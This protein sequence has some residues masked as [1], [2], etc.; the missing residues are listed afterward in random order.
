MLCFVGSA[1]A[2]CEARSCDPDAET[3]TTC[4]LDP[5]TQCSVDGISL[6]RANGCI[7]IG[8]KRGNAESMLGLDDDEFEQLILEAFD[9]WTSVDCGNGKHP[10]IEVQSIGAVDTK[11]RFTCKPMPDLNVGIWVLSDQL[12]GSA[13]VNPKYGA[14]AGVTYPSFIIDSGEI[15]DSDVELNALWLLLQDT[16]VL[17][18]HLRTVAAHE[19]GHVLGLAHSKRQDALM[20]GN[21]LV[22]EDREPTLDDVKGICD[23]YPPGDLQCEKPTVDL[24]ALSQNACNEAYL[25]KQEQERQ[26]SEISSSGCSVTS[27][28][29]TTPQL[30]IS[31]ALWIAAALLLAHRWR[32]ATAT[33]QQH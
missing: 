15:F 9:R 28:F 2:Y 20:F 10:S 23:L 25:A 1:S 21:Y 8:I 14:T 31:N 19:A 16:E 17:K 7:N 27:P 22:T 24:A 29:G 32:F 18:G 11:G 13:A 4:E 26:G 3:E 5:K 6:R 33:E 12:D 30:T